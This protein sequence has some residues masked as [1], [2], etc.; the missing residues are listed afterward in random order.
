M[1]RP[2]L[3]SLQILRRIADDV[4]TFHRHYHVLYDIAQS[5]P[6]ARKVVYCEIGTFKGASACLL[7]QRPN[8]KVI[9]IDKY[10]LEEATFN[11]EGHNPHK[12]EWHFICGD[13]HSSDVVKK[14]K[15]ITNSIDILFIDGE[16]SYN[17]VTS[18]FLAYKDTV[19]SGGY[20]VFDDYND[21]TATP[22]VRRAVDD[23]VKRLI[24][25]EILGTF[26][27]EFGAEG[28]PAHVKEG[29]DF[30]IRKM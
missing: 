29:N 25:W 13:S 7:L 21:I 22:Q 12:N 17:A 18:D 10:F 2:T 6:D 20:V 23:L 24:G 9:T 5:Y 28:W 4:P 27:N 30:A 16:H 11:I 19:R 8:T 14:V 26:E 15:E 3:E 1:I